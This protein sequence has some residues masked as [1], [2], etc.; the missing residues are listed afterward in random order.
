MGILIPPRKTGQE[1]YFKQ[2]A[3]SEFTQI[4]PCDILLLSNPAQQ[5]TKKCKTHV[6][7]TEIPNKDEEMAKLKQTFQKIG[8]TL[9]KLYKVANSRLCTLFHTYKE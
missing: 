3:G 5:R 9:K 1:Y 8:Q 6:L 4:P 2:S 7:P